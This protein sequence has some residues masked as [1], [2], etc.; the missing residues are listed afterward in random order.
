MRTTKQIKERIAKLEKVKQL[1]AAI[2]DFQRFSLV[3]QD[4]RE[5]ERELSL[6]GGQNEAN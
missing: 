5:L 6:E 3:S 1:A 4:I 2:G